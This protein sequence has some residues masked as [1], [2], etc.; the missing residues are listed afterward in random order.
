MSANI[1]ALGAVILSICTVLGC[2]VFI[3]VVYNQV[4]SINDEIQLDI[5]EFNVRQFL[6]S[7]Q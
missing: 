7:Y 1:A 2:L 6:F 5:D 3:P 4:S